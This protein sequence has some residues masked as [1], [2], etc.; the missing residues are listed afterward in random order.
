MEKMAKPIQ[1]RVPGESVCFVSIMSFFKSR[2]LSLQ[3][4]SAKLHPCNL[5]VFSAEKPILTEITAKWSFQSYSLY[6]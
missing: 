6:A 1:S 5:L 2:L 3:V 4:K